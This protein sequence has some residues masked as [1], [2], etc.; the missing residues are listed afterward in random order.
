[1]FPV[2]WLEL[3]AVIRRQWWHREGRG[4]CRRLA[5]CEPRV[6]LRRRLLINAQ[7][8]AHKVKDRVERVPVLANV[9]HDIAK[10]TP[11]GQIA[12]IGLKGMRA[13][14]LVAAGRALCLYPGDLSERAATY[15]MAAGQ[16]EAI[17]RFIAT[18]L[19]L[20]LRPF[21]P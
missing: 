13:L 20:R 16:D 18:L 9:L 10:R 7:L 4:R 2:S 1:M 14:I 12:R 6:H 11:V 3:L 19:C 17:V 21:A 5:R 8:A 15:R